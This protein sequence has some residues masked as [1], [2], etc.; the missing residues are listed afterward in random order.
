MADLMR[1]VQ[2]SG[3]RARFPQLAWME[4][5]EPARASVTLPQPA[6][7]EAAAP[8]LHHRR[9][10][11]ANAIDGDKLR[12]FREELEQ[13]QARFAY[14]CHLSTDTIQRAE[15]TRQGCGERGAVPGEV[16]ANPQPAAARTA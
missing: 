12:Q 5:D 10:R 8:R 7:P 16:E 14:L 1:Q 2:D 15:K 13:T 11:P 3:M 6:I 9:G 4:L